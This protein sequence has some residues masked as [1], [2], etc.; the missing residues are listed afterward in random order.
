MHTQIRRYLSLASAYAKNLRPHVKSDY[1]GELRLVFQISPKANE[2]PWNVKVWLP[3][4]AFEIQKHIDEL[5]PSNVSP[6]ECRPLYILNPGSDPVIM[7]TLVIRLLCSKRAG[8][9]FPETAIR[10]YKHL[11]QHI[12]ILRKEGE[13][14]KIHQQ[15]LMISKDPYKAPV[16]LDKFLE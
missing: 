11:L 12:G 2:L 6:A 4:A 1:Q 3:H 14:L 8:Q 13:S 7:I 5:L 16:P 15:T 10:V 9:S